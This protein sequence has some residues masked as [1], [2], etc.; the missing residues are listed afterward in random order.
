MQ[1]ATDASNVDLDSV[2]AEISPDSIDALAAEHEQDPSSLGERTLQA[3]Y[4]SSPRMEGK[5]MNQSRFTRAL[6]VKPNAKDPKRE[7]RGRHGHNSFP[8]NE[9]GWKAAPREQWQ[10]QKSALQAK[11]EEGWQPMKRLSPDALAGIRA[12][13]AQMPD[14]YTAATLADNFKVSPEAIRRI[15]K[16]KWTPRQEEE[17]DRQK[18]WFKRGEKVW[19]RWAEEEKMK[20]PK[21]WRELGVGKGYYAKK[22][23]AESEAESRRERFVYH[24]R[25]AM[26]VTT[27]TAR[28]S[29]ADGGSWD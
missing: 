29:D 7:Q 6:P 5:G 15:L 20:P 25:A 17:I 23:V 3:P 14:V 11:F 2:F 16:S 4:P 28:P 21:R 18:R 27:T 10:I 8:E 24:T 22:K 13:H 1:Y 26:A 9:K 12:L 19:S